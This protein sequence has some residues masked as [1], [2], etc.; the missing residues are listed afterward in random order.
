[1]NRI[2]M[3]QGNETYKKILGFTANNQLG[4]AVDLLLDLAMTYGLGS[5]H[6]VIILKRCIIEIEAEMLMGKIDFKT[7][8]EIKNQIAFKLLELAK[9]ISC[10]VSA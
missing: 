9:K 5:L 1:M 4:K 10:E 8:S 3:F 6:A 7:A 2:C